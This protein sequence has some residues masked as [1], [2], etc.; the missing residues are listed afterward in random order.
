MRNGIQSDGF[1]GTHRH[2][3]I[4]DISFQRHKRSLFDYATSKEQLYALSTTDRQTTKLYQAQ[5]EKAAS[6]DTDSWHLHRLGKGPTAP[7]K[8]SKRHTGPPLSASSWITSRVRTLVTQEQIILKIGKS[9][10]LDSR[11][12][13]QSLTTSDTS[14]LPKVSP[15]FGARIPWSRHPN[16]FIVF[17]N[18]W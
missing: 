4:L 13:H 1:K 14:Q 9:K 7:D 15:A 10:S 3:S 8:R 11:V 18:A 17:D 16:A 12:C 6:A 5:S 2:C